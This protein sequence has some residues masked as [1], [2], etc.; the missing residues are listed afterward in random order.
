MLCA[1]MQFMASPENRARYFAR[2]FAGWA[3]FSRS[4]PGPVHCGLT[5]LQ[6]QGYLAGGIVTQNVDRLHTKAGSSNVLELHGTTH[7]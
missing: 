3:E 4:A 5:R 2:S 7:E 1:S 6:Q